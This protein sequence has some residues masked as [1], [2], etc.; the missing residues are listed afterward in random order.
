M[1]PYNLPKNRGYV[2]SIIAFIIWFKMCHFKVCLVAM[3]G[4]DG[5][6]RSLK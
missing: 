4:R 2:G 6:R 3:I 5:V 1:Q